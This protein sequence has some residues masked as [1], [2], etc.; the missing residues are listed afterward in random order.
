M[1]MNLS[2]LVITG[3]SAAVLLA[4]IVA[5]AVVT[6]DSRAKHNFEKEVAAW[7]QQ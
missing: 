7:E 1:L 2:S 5:S 6:Q 4:D 3:F